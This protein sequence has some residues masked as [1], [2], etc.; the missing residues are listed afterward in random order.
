MIMKSNSAYMPR[1]KTEVK[2]FLTTELTL[3]NIVL[4]THVTLA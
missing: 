4:M 2:V 3:I 1:V